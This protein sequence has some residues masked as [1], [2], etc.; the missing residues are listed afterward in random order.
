VGEYFL[1]IIDKKGG[2]RRILVTDI[3]EISP[4]QGTKF[5][6]NYQVSTLAS[7]LLSVITNG[8][9]TVKCELF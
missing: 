7:E 2:K 3:E 4:T 8:K 9:K 6:L 1:E 5:Y